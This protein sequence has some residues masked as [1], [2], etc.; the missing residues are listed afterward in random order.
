MDFPLSELSSKSRKSRGASSRGVSVLPADLLSARCLGCS[1]EA[2]ASW[3]G[4]EGCRG[5][6]AL[7]KELPCSSL[8]AS[9]GFGESSPSAPASGAPV[10]KGE[11][12][13]AVGFVIRVTR[14]TLSLLSEG[15]ASTGVGLSVAHISTEASSV[16]TASAAKM[17]KASAWITACEEEE[18]DP[19]NS[20]VSREEETPRTEETMSGKQN[21][22]NQYRESSNLQTQ[23]G[24]ELPLL[25][26]AQGE[27][28]PILQLFFATVKERLQLL[29]E[30]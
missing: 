10:H 3:G 27:L 19:R 25:S 15:V 6:P 11:E 14:E 17:G 21:E 8:L 22:V 30:S 18:E 1:E 7:A 24:P 13:P 4:G 16:G 20:S 2:V 28:R 26:K 29:S 23:L 12:G 5:S 9:C